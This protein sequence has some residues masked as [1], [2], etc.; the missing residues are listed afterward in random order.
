[1]HRSPS[2]CTVSHPLDWPQ[3]ATDAAQRAFHT[4][5]TLIQSRCETN[6]RSKGRAGSARLRCALQLPGRARDGQRARVLCHYPETS[7]N[8]YFQPYCQCP[9]ESGAL[10]CR[11]VQPSWRSARTA[12]KDNTNEGQ[13]QPRLHQAGAIVV[14]SST[15]ASR[16]QFA[17][18][19]QQVLTVRWPYNEGI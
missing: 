18:T 5:E 19:F 2:S 10:R 15:R 3:A 7:V 9:S 14:Q 12:T 13:Y 8:K 16:A 6:W 1:M 11:S 4:H 17:P